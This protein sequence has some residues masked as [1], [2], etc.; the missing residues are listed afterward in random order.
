ML[1]L[2]YFDRHVYLFTF[3]IFNIRFLFIL[4]I[5]IIQWLTRFVLSTSTRVAQ[6]TIFLVGQLLY[7]KKAN[8]NRKCDIHNTI[9]KLFHYCYYFHLLYFKVII[10][11]I[12][13]SYNVLLLWFCNTF[14]VCLKGLSTEKSNFNVW[15]SNLK[16]LFSV[17]F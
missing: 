13:K 7:K 15:N 5:Y 1:V 8:V 9:I 6:V 3:H 14:T 12:N 2:S 11:K 16:L 10:I 17:Q 4:K